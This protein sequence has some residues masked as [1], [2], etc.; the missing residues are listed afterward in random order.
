M[1][2]T[3][4]LQKKSKYHEMYALYSKNIDYWSADYL[5]KTQHPKILKTLTTYWWPKYCIRMSTFHDY[6]KQ[7]Y[8][9]YYQLCVANQIHLSKNTFTD[10]H[11]ENIE[12]SLNYHSM[13]QSTML[14]Q[15]SALAL[16]R[17]LLSKRKRVK[18]ADN[19][20]EKNQIE[21]L[22]AQLAALSSQTNFTK[23]R[24][25]SYLKELTGYELN[26]DPRFKTTPPV[27][28]KR[29]PSRATRVFNTLMDTNQKKQPSVDEDK[30]KSRDDRE[31][32]LEAIYT[33]DVAGQIFMKYLV[34]RNK[35]FPLNRLKCLLEII[36]YKDLFYDENFNHENTKNVA[37]VRI[38]HI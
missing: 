3:D 29:P 28:W 38:F 36:K 13:V 17:K 1:D 15:E 21:A 16:N 30:P 37:R 8:P 27:G 12:K 9:L 19:G 7:R 5:L 32:F 22:E 24:R 6:V 10:L 2:I 23:Q 26:Y 14:K 18:I 35:T 33:E 31:I 20:K 11:A 34:N 4:K 25:T